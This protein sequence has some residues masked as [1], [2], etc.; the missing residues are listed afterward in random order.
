M[1][2]FAKLSL[3]FCCLFDASR[4]LNLWERAAKTKFRDPLPISAAAQSI[5]LP[6]NIFLSIYYFS[7]CLI[8]EYFYLCFFVFKMFAL[9]FPSLFLFNGFNFLTNVLTMRGTKSGLFFLR[10][11]C[12]M[13]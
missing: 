2:Y 13:R 4:H 11:S 1:F 12:F 5:H 10:F 6:C 8:D 7:V 3:K 9:S